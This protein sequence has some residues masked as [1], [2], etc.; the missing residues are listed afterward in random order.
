MNSENC[1]KLIRANENPIAEHR[2]TIVILHYARSPQLLEVIINPCGSLNWAHIAVTLWR[3]LGSR[4]HKGRPLCVPLTLVSAKIV[5]ACGHMLHAT[6]PVVRLA[7]KSSGQWLRAS[8]Y[9]LLLLLLLLPS[10]F[11]LVVVSNR[12]SLLPTLRQ[13]LSNYFHY[14]V[15]SSHLSFGFSSAVY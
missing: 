12:L 1:L 4:C 3:H 8:S 6:P 15:C 5:T 2:E 9:L 7:A 10:S 11:V 13:L 14:A